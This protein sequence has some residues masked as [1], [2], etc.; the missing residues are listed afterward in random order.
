M[1]ITAIGTVVKDIIHHFDGSISQSL[2]GL[3]YT[4]RALLSLLHEED[5]IIPVSY[6]GEDVYER[7]IELYS[8]QAQVGREGFLYISRPNNAVELS[9][10]NEAERQE[11]SLYPFPEIPFSLLQPFLTADVLLIN[12]ISGWDISLD[13]LRQIRQNFKGLISIDIH[14]LAL[15]R[16]E[17]G[18][19]YLRPI[20]AGG[21]IE[22]CD[23]I[24]ANERELEALGGNPGKPEIFLRDTCFKEKKI[25]NLTRAYLG[26][27]TYYFKDHKIKRFDANP[28]A[29]FKVIDPTGCGDA[30]VAGFVLDYFKNR[31]IKQAARAANR[32]A[33]Y[34]GTFKGLPGPIN[35]N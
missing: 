21:W 34:T 25:F 27:S 29:E 28:P 9:Y 30:F 32:I 12:M 7:I 18:L 16:E 8:G 17:N 4:I 35:A 20:E 24:Q 23:I 2:G 10:M 31:D 15:G 19:R 22:N 14:S 13:T 11:R 26:S 5:T 3:T 6:A 33:A 1:K